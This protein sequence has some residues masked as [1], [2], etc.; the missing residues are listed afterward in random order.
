[1]PLPASPGN[2]AGGPGALLVHPVREVVPWRMD[3][4]RT[5]YLIVLD[6]VGIG[7]A[8]DAAEYGDAGASSIAHTAQ[9]VGGLRMPVLQSMG[10]GNIPALLP[11]GIPILGVP[12]ADAPRAGYGA[13]RERSKGKDTTTGHWEMAG[14]VLEKPFHTFPPG[15]PSFPP[16]LLREFERRTGRR[17]IGDKA[18]SG[19][20]IIDELGEEQMRTG[21]WIV[22]TSADSVFQ[23]A[24]H[25]EV[26]PL[27]ELYRGCEI[28]RALCDPYMIGRVIARPF[29]GAP[30]AFHR[31]GNRR[32][33]SYPPIAPTILDRLL[34]RDIPVTGVGKIED[35][36][37]ER[38]ISR[39]LH[40][41]NNADT[42]AAV[43]ELARAAQPGLV[44][45][46]LIDFDML[47]GHRRDAAGYARALEDADRFIGD[48]S[49]LLRPNDLILVTADHGNDPT[50]RGTDHTREYVP[51][52]TFSPAM[53][54]RRLGIRDGFCD[55]AQ[56]LASF[57]AIDAMP[58][59]RSFLGP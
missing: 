30:G 13:M 54:G 11:D 48:L 4:D 3:M 56:T 35:I 44:F 58:H 50:F 28:A 18:Y 14:I 1:M 32:D 57:F 2:G 16:E 39:S 41:T 38:G 5:A 52:I 29:V 9:A 12:P 45:A 19:T 34:E 15:P 49:S 46:N 53:P 47:W 17:A 25:E 36:F 33:F 42:Q 43:L 6:S 40:T 51:L 8:P 27:S 37:A 10:L 24:A 23:I 59:G 55:I 7:A 26:I 20:A 22:Y 31:T 21:A